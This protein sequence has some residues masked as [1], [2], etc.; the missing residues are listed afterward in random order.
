MALPNVTESGTPEDLPH[1]PVP[2]RVLLDHNCA[3]RVHCAKE[4]VFLSPDQGR[5]KSLLG[6]MDGIDHFIV[7]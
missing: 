1:A 4:L 3:I 6:E 5:E 2:T 7:C